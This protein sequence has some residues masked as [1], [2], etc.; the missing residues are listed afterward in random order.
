MGFVT[1]LQINNDFFHEIEAN[2]D[3]FVDEIRDLM[4]RGGTTRLGRAD[5]KLARH[6]SEFHLYA[7]KHTCLIPLDRY[8]RE[9]KELVASNPEY[10][11][12]LLLLAQE[13]INEALKLFP[14]KPTVEIERRFLVKVEDMPRLRGEEYVDIIQAYIPST[15]IVVRV[16]TADH[17]AYLTLK[18][19]KVGARADEFEYEIP[20]ED[21]KKLI[22]K[23]CTLS[24]SKRRYVIPHGDFKIELDVFKGNLKGIV[25][26]EVEIPDETIEFDIPDWFGNEITYN[27]DYSNIK[28]AER[29]G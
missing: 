2:P 7:T 29:N 20:I 5:V 23:Y 9:F 3:A 8:N 27:R 6:S 12:D 17:K 16:R 13:R 10:A 14:A 24:L 15:G 28:L 11:K 26:A 1:P 4:N 25:I 22:K 21:A 19:P 18:G